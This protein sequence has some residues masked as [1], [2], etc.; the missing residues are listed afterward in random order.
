[1]ATRLATLLTAAVLMT[2]LTACGDDP[3]GSAPYRPAASATD[4]ATPSTA[5]PATPDKIA[6]SAIDVVRVES[7]GGECADGACPVSS[8]VVHGDGS[9]DAVEGDDARSGV[10]DDGDLDRL[11]RLVHTDDLTAHPKDTRSCESWVDGRDV[12]V[13]YASPTGDGQVRVSSCDYDLSGSRLL[14]F[15]A[16]ATA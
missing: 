14:T 11:I 9:F 2:S 6:V 10:L 5:P 12:V 7:S 15:L 3:A 16:A 4:P 13:T 8:I 1:M